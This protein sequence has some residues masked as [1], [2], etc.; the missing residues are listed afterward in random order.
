MENFSQPGQ[1]ITLTAP[2]GGVVSGAP[3]KVGS[4][5]VIATKDVAE[6]LPFPALTEGVVDVPKVGDEVWTEGLKIYYDA[7]PSGFT[8]SAGGNT[9]V[10]VAVEA[11]EGTVDL[12]LIEGLGSDGLSIEGNVITILDY[13]ELAGAT[14]VV[15]MGAV[16]TSL[17]EDSAGSEDWEAIT[18]NEATATSL[19]LALDGLDGINDA[20]AVGAVITVT[21]GTGAGGKSPLVGRVRLDGAVR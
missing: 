4:L 3:Y 20:T 1:V 13:A 6:A 16:S 12:D 9:L 19:A 21:P 5:V 8:S 10:G 7:S 15:K 18:S 2:G 11:L 14:V 17:L